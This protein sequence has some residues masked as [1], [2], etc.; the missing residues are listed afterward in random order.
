MHDGQQRAAGVKLT[1]SHLLILEQRLP[2]WLPEPVP[3]QHSHRGMSCNCQI[4][5]H[6]VLPSPAIH[7]ASDKCR[8]DWSSRGEGREAAKL[9]EAGLLKLL[10]VTPLA[11]SVLSLLLAARFPAFK[12]CP[13][14]LADHSRIGKC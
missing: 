4:W 9:S 2:A 6:S 14:L 10:H 13:A 12:C 5:R 1:A 8:P 7:A 11:V 3:K